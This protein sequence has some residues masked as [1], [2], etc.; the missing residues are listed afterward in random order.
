MTDRERR[1]AEGYLELA[2]L[3]WDAGLGESTRKILESAFHHLPEFKKSIL[4]EGLRFEFKVDH[5]RTIS[6]RS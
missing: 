2:G 5:G 1:A 6:I 3:L 4:H